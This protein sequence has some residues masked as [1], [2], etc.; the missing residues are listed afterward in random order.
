MDVPLYVWAA[1]LG[2]IAAMLALDLL[3]LHRDAH[4]VSMKEA[5]LTSAMWVSLGVLFG[6]GVWVGGGGERGGGYFAG[7]L[8]EKSLSVDNIFVLALIFGVFGVPS[9]FQPRVLFWGGGGALVL[10]AGFIFAGA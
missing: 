5:A 9:K 3:V 6:V 8:I 2:G 7:Y 4:E 10:R 1:T